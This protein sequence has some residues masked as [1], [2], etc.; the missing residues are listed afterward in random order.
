M[1]DFRYEDEEEKRQDVESKRQY[2]LNRSKEKRA[3][4]AEMM[5]KIKYISFLFSSSFPQKDFHER[6]NFELDPNKPISVMSSKSSQCRKLHA[7]LSLLHVPLLFPSI[8]DRY[9]F[10]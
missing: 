6:Q 10:A 5:A 4:D 3:K 8:L 1:L 2:L 9:C 7:G